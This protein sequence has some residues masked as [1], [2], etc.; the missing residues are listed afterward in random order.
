MVFARGSWAADYLQFDGESGTG[1][2]PGLGSRFFAGRATGSAGD[3]IR[4]DRVP[5]VT[6]LQRPA[7]TSAVGLAA[8]PQVVLPDMY[9]SSQIGSFPLFPEGQYNL[10]ESSAAAYAG[11]LATLLAAPLAWC[12]RRHRS[13]NVFWIL[14]AVLGLSWCL[15][16]PGVVDFLSLPGVNLLSYNRLVFATAFAILALTATGLET[17]LNGECS[18]RRGFWL[19]AALLAGLCFWCV[20]RAAVLPEPLATHFQEIIQTGEP[21][22]WAKDIAGLR[23]AQAWFALHYKMSA[24]GCG[25]GLAV[26]L[27]FRFGL[28]RL[29]MLAPLIGVLLLGDLLWFSHGRNYQCDPALYYPEIPA[30]RAVAGAAPGRVIGYNCLP[31]NLAEAV[32]LSDVRGDDGVDPG[33]WGPC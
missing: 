9:G 18:W 26:W 21:V 5:H 10:P 16:L 32:G 33:R 23:Q 19:P 11:V 30:L 27:V 25:A 14:L 17:L 28:L 1:L 24:A 7:G 8:L 4:A 13:L 29:R 2:D 15:D 12:S 22:F 31:A 3:G 20:Y 6:A